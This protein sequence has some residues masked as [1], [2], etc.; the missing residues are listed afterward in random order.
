MHL[1]FASVSR[2]WIALNQLLIWAPNPVPATY[3]SAMGNISTIH[4]ITLDLDDTL[5]DTT[6]VILLAEEKTHAWLTRHYP[7]VTEKYAM[8]D[9][10]HLRQQVAHAEPERAHDFT[11]MRR[12]VFRWLAEEM[13]YPVEEFVEAAF[14]EYIEHRH[15]VTFFEDVLPVLKMLSSRYKLAALSN[16]NAD[17]HRLG[18]GSFFEFSL[19]AREIGRPKPHPLMFQHACQRLGSKPASVVHVGDHPEHDIEGAAAAGLRTIWLNRDN[20]VWTSTV[21]PDAEI[22]SL[23]EIAALLDNWGS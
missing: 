11:Y 18:L 20:R 7:R 22:N 6:P 12:K 14:E 13:G 10:M 16:G 17:V 8:Q 21:T 2:S 4:A 3:N 23:H 9:L 19:T 1:N 5:W 15:A